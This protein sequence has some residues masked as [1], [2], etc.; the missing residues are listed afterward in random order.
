M[1]SQGKIGDY[2]KK[3]RLRL[4]LNLQMCILFSEV[5]KHEDSLDYAKKSAKLSIHLISDT[6]TASYG[7]LIS[8]YLPS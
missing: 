4:Q 6:L 2:L 1:I 8:A 7:L 5:G 3:I